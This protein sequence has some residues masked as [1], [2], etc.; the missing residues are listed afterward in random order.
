MDGMKAILVGGARDGQILDV[1]DGALVIRVATLDRAVDVRAFEI[2]E[3]SGKPPFMEL[4]V[5]ITI[6]RYERAGLSLNGAQV[7]RLAS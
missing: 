7:Y 2:T 6:L 4:P 5:P 1:E 3:E